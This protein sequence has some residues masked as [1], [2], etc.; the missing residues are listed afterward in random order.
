MKVSI[1]GLTT[2]AH[3][4]PTAKGDKI[5]A[6]FSFRADFV[7]MEGAALVLLHSGGFTTWEPIRGNEK[8]PSRSVR[9]TGAA[10]HAVAAAALPFYEA[11][12]G[13]L[14]A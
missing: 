7:E 6:W 2:V 13:D 9:M 3:P 5:V 1:T 14:E 10:R 12:T 4:K 8:L 11:M